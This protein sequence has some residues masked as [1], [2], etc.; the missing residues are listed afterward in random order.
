[1]HNATGQSTLFVPGEEEQAREAVLELLAGGLTSSEAVQVALLNNQ[2]LQVQLFDIG[3]GH[4]DVVQA[5]LLANPSLEALVRFPLNGGSSTSEGGLLQNLA[6]LW[7]IPARKRIAQSELERTVLA[8]AHEAASVAAEAKSAYLAAVAASQSLLVAKENLATAQLFHELSQERL[9]AGGATQVD[10]NAA[11]SK[12][13]EQRV[14]ERV[15]RF[16]EVQAKLRLLATIGLQGSQQDL[17]LTD[18]LLSPGQLTPDLEALLVNASKHRLDLQSVARGVEAAERS[19]PLERRRV[20]R[21]LGGGV[22]FEAQGGEVAL[23]PALELSLPIFDQNQAQIAK[24]ELRYAQALRQLDGLTTR[25]SQQ[26]RTAHAKYELALETVRLYDR[27]LLPL[28]EQSLEL[29]RES[30]AAGKTGFLHVLEAQNELLAA[31]REYV[32]QQAS[33][34][35]SIP[36]LE[37]AC[38]RPIAELLTPQD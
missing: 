16:G 7:R 25:V 6:D 4:A 33:L 29:A 2:R 12:L 20:W 31:R 22:A 13:L 37:A 9:D 10:V 30:F 8:V 23:G 11:H 32:T 28:R 26:V 1:V 19:I 3:L 27:E 35:S 38:G 14:I 15:A 24:A 5:G 36:S 34:A 17:E 18:A 21:A